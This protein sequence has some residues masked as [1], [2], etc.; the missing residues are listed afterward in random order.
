MD[1]FLTIYSLV[2]IIFRFFTNNVNAVKFVDGDSCLYD[3]YFV[4]GFSKLDRHDDMI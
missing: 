1:F 4:I 2:G 3:A